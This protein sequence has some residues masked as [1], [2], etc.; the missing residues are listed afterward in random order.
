MM[1]VGLSVLFLNLEKM[2][3][4]FTIEYNFGNGFSYKAFLYCSLYPSFQSRFLF[5]IHKTPLPAIPIHILQ[6]SLISSIFFQ[7]SS[8]KATGGIVVCSFFLHVSPIKIIYVYTSTYLFLSHLPICVVAV[9]NTGYFNN[10]SK[11]Q[12]SYKYKKC[13]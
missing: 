10:I 7:N 4:S 3:S 6:S 8:L 5:S 13:Y 11:M 1:R 12:N 9:L 2:F